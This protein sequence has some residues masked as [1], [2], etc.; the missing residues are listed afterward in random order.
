M[1]ALSRYG[2]E[3]RISRLPSGLRQ[4]HRLICLVPD[5]DPVDPPDRGP[6]GSIWYANVDRQSL[7][8]LVRMVRSFETRS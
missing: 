1:N 8:E 6:P 7:A 5:E 4:E 2:H 3:G